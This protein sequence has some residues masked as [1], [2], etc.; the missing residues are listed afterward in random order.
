MQLVNI[1]LIIFGVTMIAIALFLLVWIKKALATKKWHTTEGT[2]I[3]SKLESDW[4]DVEYD[5]YVNGKYYTSNRLYYGQPD[6]PILVNLLL[7]MHKRLDLTPKTKVT[8]YYDVNNPR[9]SLLLPGI[10]RRWDKIIYT[11]NTSLALSTGLASLIAAF[12]L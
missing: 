9:K 10:F 2:I 8:V 7:K 3:S 4:G 11:I 1:I 6:N 12:Y 5:Y